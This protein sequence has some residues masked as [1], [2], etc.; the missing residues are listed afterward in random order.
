MQTVAWSGGQWD[1]RINVRQQ[2][3]VNVGGVQCDVL[4]SMTA[5]YGQW[6][7]PSKPA[8]PLAQPTKFTADGH[9]SLRALAHA[10]GTGPAHALWVTST[11]RAAGWGDLQ[12]AYINGE[13][14]DA[15]MPAGMVIWLG[16]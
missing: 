16:G 12:T 1:R 6:P 9:T 4:T 7:R 5:D 14:W 13:D 8:P 11:H 15:P 3:M 2:L 10:H